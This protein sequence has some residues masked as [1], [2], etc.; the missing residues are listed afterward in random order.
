MKNVGEGREEKEE[1]AEGCCWWYGRG[2]T[3]EC[4][5]MRANARATN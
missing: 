2:V 5:S 1:R 3:Q 4:L